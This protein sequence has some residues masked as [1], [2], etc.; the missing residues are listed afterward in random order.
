MKIITSRSNPLRQLCERVNRCRRQSLKACAY[1]G[2]AVCRIVL[3][4][5][6]LF[7]AMVKMQVKINSANADGSES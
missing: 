6:R 4:G 2:G 7:V 5:G 3:S 1:R